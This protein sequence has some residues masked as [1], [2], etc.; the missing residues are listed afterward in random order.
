[1]KT[2]HRFQHFLPPKKFIQK[3]E[4][5]ESNNQMAQAETQNILD[6]ILEE[7]F[8]VKTSVFELFNQDG[9]PK[10]PYSSFSPPKKRRDQ[11]EKAYKTL[12]KKPF[13]E[14]INCIV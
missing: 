1:M 11:F 7:V 4:E 8:G 12:F 6:K 5:G 13:T 2:I 10:N 9:T 3:I 14:N